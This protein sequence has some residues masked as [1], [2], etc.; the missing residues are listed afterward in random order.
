MVK[1]VSFYE[2]EF[3]NQSLNRFDFAVEEI[4]KIIAYRYK[5]MINKKE[6]REKMREI[7]EFL[8]I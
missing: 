6:Y 1:T 5:K 2:E 7:E 8:G 3:Q 4:K